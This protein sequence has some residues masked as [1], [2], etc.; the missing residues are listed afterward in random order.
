MKVSKK[1]F[2]YSLVAGF[3]LLFSV[4][5][6]SKCIITY[7]GQEKQ[8]DAESSNVDSDIKIPKLKARVH[9][10]NIGWKNGVNGIVGSAGKGLRLEAIQLSVSGVSGLG[11]KYRTHVQNLGWQSYVS[12]GD[13]S[14]TE[15]YGLRVE[16]IQV[17]LTGAKSS[18]YDIFYRAYVDGFGWMNWAKN[19]ELAG[20]EGYGRRLEAL[21]F[22]IVAR[23]TASYIGG[24]PAYSQNKTISMQAHMQ[25]YGWM[26]SVELGS[27]LGVTGQG[28]RLEAIKLTPVGYDM[29]IEYSV[30]IQNIGWTGYA[31]NGGMAGTTGKGLR[32]EAVKIKISGA[33][34][35]NYDIYYR[36]HVQ[37]IGWMDWAKNDEEAGTSG[38]GY[39]LE[40]LEVRL[41]P[42]GEAA[43]GSTETPYRKY[44]QQ[45][46]QAQILARQKLNQVGWELRNAFNYAASLSYYGGVPVPAAGQHLEEYAKYGFTYGKGNCYVMAA[47]FCRMAR[48]LGY[49]CYLVEGYVPR[50]GGGI[51]VHGWTEI[52]INGKTYVCDPDF[53]NETKR[54]GYMITYGTSGTWV[55]QKYSRVN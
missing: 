54:N 51:T 2:F 12:D 16:A 15:G 29:D 34:A 37:N 36:A 25:D 35:E 24:G 33:D 53:T 30:H 4:L 21:E 48:E 14:G 10:Q 20:S 49:E 11:I 31:R 8:S 27:V 13:T 38:Y 43:P 22:K 23:G 52:V 7:A 3:I 5:S 41:V 9:M 19:G 6:G 28:K 47:V 39:R 40:A 50:R 32:I 18:D 44:V 17:M 45:F 42:K 1:I 26:S 46:T 55:Y